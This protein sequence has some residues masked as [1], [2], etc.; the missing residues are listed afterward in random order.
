M[1]IH[2]LKIL[3]QYFIEVKSG[4]KN[5]ELRKNDRNYQT[6]DILVLNEWN[7]TAKCYAGNW[8]RVRATYILEDAKEYGL[9]DGF[10]IIGFVLED[11]SSKTAED[12]LKV[13]FKNGWLVASKSPDPDY[14]GIDVEY[15]DDNTDD[16]CLSRPRVLFEQ[17]M[18]DNETATMR[19]LI[20]N[21]NT[22]EDYS[23]EV[24]F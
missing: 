24:T 7:N 22:S 19:A 5:F 6:G 3:S 21:D 23:E 18:V 2:E 14:P 17:P 20:W 9:S 13:R 4:R 16:S 15:V 11:N 10:C 12:E 8:V 1:K